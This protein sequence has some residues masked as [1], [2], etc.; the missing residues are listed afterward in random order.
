MWEEAAEEATVPPK[1][2]IYAKLTDTV[3]SV[4]VL[5]FR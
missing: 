5:A 1:G 4:R 2:L 3:H